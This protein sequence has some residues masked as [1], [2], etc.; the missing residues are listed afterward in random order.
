MSATMPPAEPSFQT[1]RQTL[2]MRLQL[3]LPAHC[4][5]I[6]EEDLRPYECD[7]LT[8]YREL[9][10]AVCLP[11]NEGQVIDVL[12]T[13]HQLGVPVVA[14][15][16]GTGLS[17]GAM[18]H[19]QGVVLSLARFNKILRVDR[20]ARLAVVQPGVRNLAVSEAAA[21]FGLY[22]A[23]DPSSQIACTLGGNV[24]EN[25][26]GVH[27]LKYGLT[28]HNV[29]RVRVVSIEGE[30]FEIGSAAPDAPGYDLLA[31]LIGSE[32]MLGVVTEVTVKLVPKPELAQVVMASF[33][34]VSK[35]GDAVAAIIA[36]GIIPAGLEMMDKPATA[37]VEPY[38]KAGYDLNAAAILL[39]ESDGTPEEVAEEIFRMT[40]VLTAAGASNIRVSQSEA[41]RLRFWAGRKAA[42]PAIGRITPDYY[43]MDGTIP[44][45]R[46]A[47]MLAAIGEMKKKYRLH[48]ANVF[49]AGDGNLHPLIMYDT[50]K[51][52]EWARA[53]AFG[54]EILELSVALGGSITGEH[55]VGIEKINQM[56]V[57]YKTPEL[58]AFHRIKAAF[59]ENGLLN[60]GKAVP[61]LHR[62]A[63]YGRMHVHHGDVKFPELERF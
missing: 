26:G 33:D 14:R 25:S 6:D 53:E 60:P 9:P 49:H 58:E 2:A 42:F 56:C 62:C 12:R 51:P 40:E 15:G 37:A 46:L 27:C 31:L 18:P 7:G 22:Y 38:V 10:M 11:E 48:Y 17:G 13:C 52:G 45:K 5:L 43:C 39:C 21:P 61:S 23:P 29:L 1:D 32:G 54:A 8:A 28:V 20:E 63:E 50:A 3:I 36:A 41:E 4:L 30:I 34:D 59:D 16:A 24:A 47:E 44:R 19:A 57:Q 35:A 55:G